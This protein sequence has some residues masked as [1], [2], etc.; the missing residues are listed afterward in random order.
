MTEERTVLDAYLEI[1]GSSS[2]KGKKRQADSWGNGTEKKNRTGTEKKLQNQSLLTATVQDN[3]TSLQG[4]WLMKPEGHIVTQ[5][6]VNKAL[7][8]RSRTAA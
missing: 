2:K 3:R 7:A 8:L 6:Q 1:T 4:N 5:K